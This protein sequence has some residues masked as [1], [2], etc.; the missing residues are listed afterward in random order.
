MISFPNPVL[1]TVLGSTLRDGLNVWTTTYVSSTT[2]SAKVAPFR[3]SERVTCTFDASPAPS[4]TT[5][6]NPVPSPDDCAT[7]SLRIY[8]RCKCRLSEVRVE[9]SRKTDGAP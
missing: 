5:S 9:N 6:A 1:I 7:K 8:D 4:N 2:A 3:S